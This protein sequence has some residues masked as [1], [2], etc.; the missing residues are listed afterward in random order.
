[1]HPQHKPVLALAHARPSPPRHKNVFTLPK[2]PGAPAGS[3]VPRGRGAE[4]MGWSTPN[5]G[6]LTHGT[7]STPLRVPN[8]PS[9]A[10]GA[11]S[12]HCC[13]L[14]PKS[15][16]V[17]HPCSPLCALVRGHHN[18]CAWQPRGSSSPG[19]ALRMEWGWGRAAGGARGAGN[20]PAQHSPA[21]PRACA[22][23]PHSKTLSKGRSH[24]RGP[25][26]VTALNPLGLGDE[27]PRTGEMLLQ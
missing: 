25:L 5:L 13:V 15:F 23:P 6:D 16:R 14:P 9:R 10:A 7:P 4:Q 22:R 18:F 2:P 1:M 27:P 11:A 24:P 19:G 12:P 8:L 3:A 20:P 17:F 21:L 26:R